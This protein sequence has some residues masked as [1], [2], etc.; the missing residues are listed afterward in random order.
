VVKSKGRKTILLIN[1]GGGIPI[2]LMEG[3]RLKV[4]RG[5]NRTIIIWQPMVYG[6]KT[7]D[8]TRTKKGKDGDRHLPRK[9]FAMLEEGGNLAELDGAEYEVIAAGKEGRGGPDKNER[10]GA[11]KD[12]GPRKPLLR[13]PVWGLPPRWR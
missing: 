5:E 13:R 7:P 8:L 3:D 4:S 2:P 10:E 1:T 12:L 9:F 6:C 11:G